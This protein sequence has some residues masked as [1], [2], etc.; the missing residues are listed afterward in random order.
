M[1]KYTM[2]GIDVGTTATKAV[3]IDEK[4][5]RLAGYSL[6][7]PTRRPKPGYAEQDPTDW[8][9]G[10]SGAL[11]SFAKAHDLAGL[12]AIGICS[13]VNTHI[14][15]DQSGI[16][17]LPAMTWQDGRSAEDAAGIEARTSN[18]QKTAWLGAPMPIDASHA[19]SR[20][21]HVARTDPDI[22]ARTA[23]VLL[24]KDYCVLQLTGTVQSDPISAVGLVNK[25]GYVADLLNLVEG[26]ADKLPPLAGFT[27]VVGT[28]RHGLP[29][30]GTP[31]VVGAMDAWGGMFG[32]GVVNDGDA[33]YQSGTSEIPGIVSST[34]VPTPGVI[35]FPPYEGILMHAAPTQSGGAALGW[36]ANVLGR[37]AAETAALGGAAEP[38]ASIPIFLPH[39]QGE[40]AP[41]WD[42]ASRGVFARLDPSSGSAEMAR[43][44][45]EGVAYS[46]RLAFD[47]LKQSAACDPVEIN[48][49]GGGAMS[50]DWCQIRAD[51]LGK[52]LKRC[53]SPETAALGA[54]IL[55][56]L[57][58]GIGKSLPDAVG[59]LVQFDKTFEPDPSMATYHNDRFDKY[60][61]LYRDLVGFN[62][63][64]RGDGALNGQ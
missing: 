15:V 16:P 38:G 55:A 7:H 53:A 49:G 56:G 47:A 52:P 40:R 13:Q 48:I 20:M 30:A 3:L 31:V 46:V 19:L 60:Q 28:V 12:Q 54:A 25:N 41:L 43:G 18:E 34:L 17:L 44:V 11:E 45:L 2:I 64:F 37:T 63:L 26:A 62:A 32:V 29:C 22:Y 50:D 58:Q 23:H 27:D 24:P 21:A 36:F 57:S 59:R 1:A 10:V 61:M 33:M 4:G 8:M 51:V 35:T 39:L 5:F 9:K 6:P 42:S 14:F